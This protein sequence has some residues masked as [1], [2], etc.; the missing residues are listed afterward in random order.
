MHLWSI[1]ILICGIS[2]ATTA[3]DTTETSHDNSSSSPRRIFGLNKGWK[4]R[5]TF[6]P[7]SVEDCDTT[8]ECSSNY[9]DMHWKSVTVPHDF[10]VEGL[11]NETTGDKDHGYLPLGYSWYRKHF[12]IPLL[13]R[14]TWRLEFEGCMWRCHVYLNQQYLGTSSSGYL[15]FWFNNVTLAP[16]NNVLVVLA[17]ATKPDSWWYDGGGLYRDVRLVALNDKRI[18]K[19]GV[20]APS[21]VISSIQ[22]ETLETPATA[23]AIVMI[24]V[25]VEQKQDNEQI[26]VEFWITDGSNHIVA[27][28]RTT[29]L[30]AS[31]AT[32]TTMGV[33]LTIA[34]A[35]LWSIDHPSLY[36]L[37]TSL[38]SVTNGQV[39]DMEHTT[40]GI[41]KLAWDSE[42]GLFLNDVPTKILGVANHQDFTGLGV[43]V[44]DS[45]QAHRIAKIQELGG[46]AWRT[47]HNAPNVA[48]LDAA[49]RMGML[50]WDE[51]HRNGETEH[52]K[53]LVKRDRNHPCIIIWSICNEILCDC[54]DGTTSKTSLQKAAEIKHAFKTLDPHG[55]RVVSANQND[56]IM[57]NSV[58]DLL[59]FDYA[60]NNYDKWHAAHPTYPVISSE[61]SSAVGDRGEYANNEATGHVS[62][63]GTEAVPWGQTTEKAWGGYDEGDLNNTQGILTRSFVAG[64]FTWTGFDYKGEPTPYAWPDISSHFGIYD[65]AGF[66]K[67]R[68]GW[69][70]SWWPLENNKPHV[71]RLFLFP[72]WNWAVGEREVQKNRHLTQCKND[73]GEVEVRVYSNAANVELFLNGQSQGCKAMPRY[74]HLAWN[75]SFTPGNIT[76]RSYTSCDS[77]DA[78]QEVARVTTG[79]PA[80][81]EA[82][83]KD[84]VGSGGIREDEVALVEVKIL[85]AQDRIVPVPDDYPVFVKF[86][87]RCGGGKLI[88]TGNGDPSDLTSDKSPVRKAYH[89]SALG[90]VQAVPSSDSKQFLRGT[91]QSEIEV[92]ISSDGF[93]DTVI[94]VSIHMSGDESSEPT[95]VSL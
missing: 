39:L 56:W 18:A 77:I 68:V 94:K 15:P 12:N 87:V 79:P 59:G 58:L 43:A 45:L 65:I 93:D 84:G 42:L 5:T 26:Y 11:F 2:V 17:D 38:V 52:A 67:D 34:D 32:T 72:H 69:Y 66:D 90:I 25:E 16:E 30:T 89:G 28:K 70:K 27:T 92:V 3:D 82:Q 8:P 9:D 22:A 57:D 6:D 40:I 75:V 21:L 64:G 78:T 29:E 48:L 60:T 62:D 36:T 13:E 88:G 63:Y 24:S 41:R 83:F 86:E 95:R 14:K 53:M 74:G 61:T 35:K 37:K 20:Y 80:K 10:V 71:D 54:G 19:Y 50:V 7:P 23:D 85:D 55:Q 91:E 76:A 44:P 47:A 51:N 81:L 4:Q 33:N 46:N 49:D 73:N 1:C 31:T